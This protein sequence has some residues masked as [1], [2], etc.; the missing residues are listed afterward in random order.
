MANDH[1]LHSVSI[2]KISA[3]ELGTG[4]VFVIEFIQTLPM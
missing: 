1:L 3:A 4:H 2:S